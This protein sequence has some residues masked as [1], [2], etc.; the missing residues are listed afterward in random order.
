MPLIK[1]IKKIFFFKN[2][3]IEC[4]D[5][6]R[7]FTNKVEF[8]PNVFD[9]LQI[10][11]YR[12]FN[13]ELV[14]FL[15]NYK[16]QKAV[17]VLSPEIA[18]SGKALPEYVLGIFRRL[19][20]KV[21]YIVPST[22]FEGVN[23]NTQLNQAQTKA[24]L[25]SEKLLRA[26]NL[27]FFSPNQKSHKNLYFLA[28]SVVLILFFFLG[29]N[30]FQNQIN[31]KDISKNEELS[32]VYIDTTPAPSPQDA[33]VQSPSPSPSAVIKKTELKIKVLNGSGVSGQA[34]KVKNE[35]LEAGFLDIETGNASVSSQLATMVEFGPDI[36]GETVAEIKTVLEDI[37]KKVGTKQN[38][39]LSPA[40]ILI[41]TGKN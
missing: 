2:K 20:F 25:N 8:P 21:Q 5:W 15:S 32:I 39:S 41:T 24:I 16:S 23:P 37:F 10:L 7:G 22:I 31:P 30:I 33:A 3:L 27:N 11:S 1:P 14:A 13:S 34:A 38:P 29:F 19:K 28:L 18:S 4:Y 12:R 35:L 17:I 26:G 9:H 40:G 6:D 36:S